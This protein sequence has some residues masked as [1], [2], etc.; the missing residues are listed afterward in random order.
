MP[1]FAA[2]RN[3]AQPISQARPNVVNPR[4]SQP[5]AQQSAP[6]RPATARAQMPDEP[7]PRPAPP[8]APAPFRMPAPEEL[9]LAAA[10]AA[11]PAAGDWPEVHRRLQ[12][13]GASGL[14]LDPLAGGGWRATFVLPASQEDKAHRVE[15]RADSPESAVRMALAEADARKLQARK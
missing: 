7:R 5:V 4:P 15:A 10:P 9:G 6:P 13:L 1:T 8:P 12:V 3:L 11:G 2:P 14:Q